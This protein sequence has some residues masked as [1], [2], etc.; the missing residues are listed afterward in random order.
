MKQRKHRSHHSSLNIHVDLSNTGVFKT[1]IA[2]FHWG[3]SGS[4][5]W[6]CACWLTGTPKWRRAISNV[7][8]YVTAGETAA[9]TCRC[10]CFSCSTSWGLTTL[11][12]AST[13][14]PGAKGLLS[15][16]NLCCAKLDITLQAVTKSE[17]TRQILSTLYDNYRIFLTILYQ[18]MLNP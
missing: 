13:S 15:L 14:S 17:P 10:W 3:A 9:M 2:A 5:S 7:V 16:S 8:S 6:H 18:N 1:F 4:G 12:R 11:W